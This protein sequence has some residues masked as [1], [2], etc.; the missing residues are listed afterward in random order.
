MFQH[1]CTKHIKIRRHFI[2]E[3]VENGIL[4]LEF[5]TIDDQKADLFT[6][7]LDGHCFKFLHQCIG[8]ISL[9]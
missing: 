4:T 7:P 8:V 3:L 5:I 6:K 1:S 2:R 9:E